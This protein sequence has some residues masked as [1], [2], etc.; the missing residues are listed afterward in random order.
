[1]TVVKLLGSQ[2]EVG[3]HGKARESQEQSVKMAG[4]VT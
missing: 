3:N 2:S 1:M 4:K